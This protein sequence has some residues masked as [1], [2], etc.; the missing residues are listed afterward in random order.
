[1]FIDADGQALRFGVVDRLFVYGSLQ[2]GAPNAHV[3]SGLGSW[4]AGSVLGELAD[5]GW[6][7]SL[8]YPGLV[9]VGSGSVVRGSVLSAEALPWEQLD[10]FEGAEYRRTMVEVTLDDRSRVR[11]AVYVLDR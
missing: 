9:S 2:P 11:A 10:E 5:A 1:M 8:G 7:A 6:G 4:A 3:L